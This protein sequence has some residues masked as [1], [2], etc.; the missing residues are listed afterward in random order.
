MML[1]GDGDD[2]AVPLEHNKQ[3]MII[4]LTIFSN[5]FVTILGWSFIV[6]LFYFVLKK[7]NVWAKK[8]WNKT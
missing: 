4:M 5:G 3:I 2:G 1:L 8:P 6:Y 7:R